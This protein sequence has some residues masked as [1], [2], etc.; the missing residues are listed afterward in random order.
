MSLSIS[1]QGKPQHSTGALDDQQ[2]LAIEGSKKSRQGGHSTSNWTECEK[3]PQ[4][5]AKTPLHRHNRH[6]RKLS[7]GTV[8]T[9]SMSCKCGTLAVFCTV[10]TS[11]CCC[12]PT[13]MPTTL[14]KN[15]RSGTIF[16]T[17]CNCGSRLSSPQTA[18]E[19]P[20]RPAQQGHRPPCQH[21]ATRESLWSS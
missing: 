1:S 6:K 19:K 14:S 17:I 2:L 11:T 21:T 15:W 13:G 4:I 8:R 9:L 7:T 16:S 3:M 5:T 18:P 10:T 20:V 12:T